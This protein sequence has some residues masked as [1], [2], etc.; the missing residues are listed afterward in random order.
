[1]TLRA[2]IRRYP[3]AA[4]AVLMLALAVRLAIPTGFMP[5]AA[6]GTITVA[7]CNGMTTTLAIPGLP[8]QPDHDKAKAAAPCAFAGLSTLA[9]GATD[10]TLLIAALAFV[11]LLAIRGQ[12]LPRAQRTAF[13]RPFLRGP[14]TIG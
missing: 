13:L 8:A 4:A 6:D 2:I 12:A 5:A 3:L 11:F 14:P 7:V 1:M 10:P 9:L